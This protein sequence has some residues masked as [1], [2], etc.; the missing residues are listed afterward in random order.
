MG[1]G[2]WWHS[3]LPFWDRA[4]GCCRCGNGHVVL[5]LF[6]LNQ[7][8]RRRRNGWVVLGF[9]H[10]IGRWWWRR[11]WGR[12]V[13][14]TTFAWGVHF[15]S[16]L[17][18]TKC[19]EIRTYVEC[20]NITSVDEQHTETNDLDGCVALDTA[21]GDVIENCDVEEETAEAN[22][23][24]S[25]CFPC[26]ANVKFRNN[27]VNACMDT[28]GGAEE[29]TTGWDW[30]GVFSVGTGTVSR[31]CS[32][33]PMVENQADFKK[34]TNSSMGR[35]QKKHLFALVGVVAIFHSC[36]GLVHRCWWTRRR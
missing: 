22:R 28:R 35:E 2:G 11:L 25:V 4:M 24:N 19:Q 1:P 20:Q 15:L 17:P 34:K 21:A 29:G 26:R 8:R 16:L 12:C 23:V 30:S 13:C 33:M 6:C 5:F 9:C 32:T 36:V 31:C 18:I 7:R 14:T 3:W 10:C 27:P